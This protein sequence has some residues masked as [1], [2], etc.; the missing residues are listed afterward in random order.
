SFSPDGRSIAYASDRAGNFDI[1]VQSIDGGAVRQITTS[2]AA[3]TQPAWSPDGNR[4]V[5]RSERDPAGLRIVSVEGGPE[6]QWTTFGVQPMW[7]ADG[8]EIVF[9]A[10]AFNSGLFAVSAEGGEAPRSLAGEF[11]QSSSWKWI[12]PHP[13]GRV[14]FAGFHRQLQSGFYTVSRD[15]HQ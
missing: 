1:W 13:D 15:S 4:I 5:F 10:D 6:R 9:R 14:S 7:S 8:S 2:V 12:A 11:A 3:E